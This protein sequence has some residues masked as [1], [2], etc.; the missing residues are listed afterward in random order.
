M[1]FMSLWRPSKVNPPTGENMAQMGQLIDE[2][3]KKGVMIETGGWYP[4]SPCTAFRSTG[5][6]LTV[7]DGPFTEAK[8]IVAGFCLM[9]VKSKAEAIEWATRFVKI[10]GDGVCEMRELDDGTPKDRAVAPMRQALER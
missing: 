8:E 6:K 2:M 5:G 9:N 10:A 1:K 4:D 3:V 7:T